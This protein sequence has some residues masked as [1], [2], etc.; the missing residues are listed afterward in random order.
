M[1]DEDDYENDNYNYNW[2]G[3]GTG[4]G[5]IFLF[6]A[7]ELPGDPKVDLTE[8]ILADVHGP[9]LGERLA[10]HTHGVVHC[11]R[12]DCIVLGGAVTISVALGED[13]DYGN[14]VIAVS[15]KGVNVVLEAEGFPKSPICIRCFVAFR[16][17]AQSGIFF[18]KAEGGK[19]FFWS[20]NICQGVVC[21]KVES[22]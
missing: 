17:D 10:H 21:G 20:W 11:S 8:C 7:P 19:R 15:D 5:C 16:S 2:G 9:P 22:K 12:A 3:L 13:L 6:V 4:W 14:G 18:D 1:Q